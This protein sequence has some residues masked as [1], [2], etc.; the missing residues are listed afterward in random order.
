MKKECLNCEITIEISRYHAN[1][2]YTEKKILTFN[3]QQDLILNSQVVF[4]WKT[5]DWKIQYF[6]IILIAC[7]IKFIICFFHW[8]CRLMYKLTKQTFNF[9][10]MNKENIHKL[11][12]TGLNMNQFLHLFNLDFTYYLLCFQF[13]KY[14]YAYVQSLKETRTLY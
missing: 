6:H 10:R 8:N 3:F 9:Y 4:Y 11:S 1:T 13:W 7:C 2:R 12:N 14:T 5:V